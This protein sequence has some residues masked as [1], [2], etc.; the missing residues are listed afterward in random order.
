LVLGIGNGCKEL[1]KYLEGSK[2]YIVTAKLGQATDT[3]DVDGKIVKEGRTDHLTSSLVKETLSTFKGQITQIPPIYSALKMNGKRLYDYA[4]ENIPLPEE[5]KPRVAFVKDIELLNY[6]N[7]TCVFRVE[8]G[9]GT[10]MRSIVHDMAIAMGTFGHMTALKRTKQG[11]FTLDDTLPLDWE[12]I[13]LV[14]VKS[15][16]EEKQQIVSLPKS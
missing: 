1:T 2:E 9:G 6:G 11:L 4:R 8:C 15:K 7:D 12:S 14:N 16:I 10:Y 3:Y 5:I 13:S